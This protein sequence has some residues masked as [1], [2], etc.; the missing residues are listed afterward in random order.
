MRL[1]QAIGTCVLLLIMGTLPSTT[2]AGIVLTI[3]DVV[4]ANNASGSTVTASLFA[5]SNDGDSLLSYN[6]PI[7]VGGDGR[8][9]PAGFSNLVFTQVVATEGFSVNLNTLPSPPFT[10]DY[11]AIVNGNFNMPP[12]VLASPQELFSLSFDIDNTVPINTLFAIDVTDGSTSNPNFF[13]IESGN[14]GSVSTPAALIAN[15]GGVVQGSVIVT[16]VPEPGSLL[17]LGSM[18]I[19][20]V[21]LRRRKKTKKA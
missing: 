8:G 4:V 10:Q 20:G 14:D 12:L 15:G 16:A 9:L 18:A 1:R 5:S 3:D 21:L 7:E 11:E 2:E 19:G 6:L 17:A 13:Q